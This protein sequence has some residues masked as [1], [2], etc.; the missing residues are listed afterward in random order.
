MTKSIGNI[1]SL[2]IHAFEYGM[3]FPT[4]YFSHFKLE[5]RNM[6]R[7]IPRMRALIFRPICVLDGFG[8][9]LKAN[10]IFG[11]P[12]IVGNMVAFPRP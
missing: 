9:G 3:D 10:L 1:E 11:K 6:I 5:I 2:K 12:P 4:I 7:K 8:K